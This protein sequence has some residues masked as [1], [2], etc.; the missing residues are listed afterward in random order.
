MTSG[1]D[2]SAS[3]LGNA[4]RFVDV[5]ISL[6]LKIGIWGV[7]VVAIGCIVAVLS[8]LSL[9]SD[10]QSADR[11]SFLQTGRI[12]LVAL[13]ALVALIFFG[14]AVSQRAKLRAAEAVRPDAVVF[15]TQRTPALIDALKTI[16]TSR[17]RLCQHFVVTLG[18]K[19]IELWGRG[20]NDVPQMVLPWSDIDYA[21]PG[22]HVVE[23][24]NISVAVLALRIFQTVNGRQLDLPFPV[25]GPRG[26]NRAGTHDANTVLTACSRYT[27]IA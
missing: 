24:G 18:P 21:H 15:M 17:P 19:G 3:S 8:V 16:G 1:A 20:R 22:R 27:S 2:V 5:P 23:T 10:G 25:F 9:G 7:A 11:M 26:I 4:V 6:P 13:G 14:T 12:A